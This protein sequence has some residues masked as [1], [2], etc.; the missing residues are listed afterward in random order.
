[1]YTPTLPANKGSFTLSSFCMP[2]I[3]TLFPIKLPRASSTM[4]NGSGESEHPRLFPDLSE[5]A[6]NLM[7]VLSFS[8]IIFIRFKEGSSVPTL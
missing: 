2:F 1:M 5:K 7:L 8:E 3:P 4:S 6:L